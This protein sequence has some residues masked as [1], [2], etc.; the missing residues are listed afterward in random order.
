[1]MGEF[2]PASR[3]IPER[4]HFS[5]VVRDDKL[6]KLINNF[7]ADLRVQ[8]RWKQQKRLLLAMQ[9]IVAGLRE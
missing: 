3:A 8:W 4:Y 1:M 9:I 7:L 5:P 2:H 6:A